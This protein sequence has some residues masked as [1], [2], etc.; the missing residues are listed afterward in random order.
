MARKALS[1]SPNNISSGDKS[2]SNNSVSNGKAAAKRKAAVSKN[3]GDADIDED[4][5][6]H[7]D[8]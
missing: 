4:D 7:L 1:A 2:S 5:D 6:E 3:Y 8:N